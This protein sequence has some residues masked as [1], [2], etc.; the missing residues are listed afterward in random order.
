MIRIVLYIIVLL[1]LGSCQ[2]NLKPEVEIHTVRDTVY[3]G[4]TFIA[5]LQVQYNDSI[6]P[7]FH[8]I[9]KEDTFYI[10][11]DMTKQ[12]AVFQAVGSTQGEKIYNG[13]VEYISKEGNKK[14]SNY[15]ISFYVE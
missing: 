13:Y 9:I 2:L 8:I 4:E 7:V 3:I 10:P 6:L 12:C 11:F 5:N 1:I 14:K 15:S